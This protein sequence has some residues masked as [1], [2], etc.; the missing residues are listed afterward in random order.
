[1]LWHAVL[2]V[3]QCRGALPG[4]VLEGTGTGCS[5]GVWPGG[6]GARVTNSRGYMGGGVNLVL[7]ALMLS[8]CACVWLDVV[9]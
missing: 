1:M 8:L 9:D 6:Q 2:V 7:T 4:G 5:V 3:L